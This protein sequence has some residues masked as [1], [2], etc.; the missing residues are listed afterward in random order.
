MLVW[1]IGSHSHNEFLQTQ[2]ELGAVGGIL[3]LAS[4]CAVTW[5]IGLLFPGPSSPTY[6]RNSTD[7]SL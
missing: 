7:F 4:G 1:K 6:W 2:Y 5:S 3:M